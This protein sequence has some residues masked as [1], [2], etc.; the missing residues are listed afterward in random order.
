MLFEM[1][2]TDSAFFMT[3]LIAIIFSFVSLY[4]VSRIRH[5]REV[6]RLKEKL[7]RVM[8]DESAVWSE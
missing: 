4:I 7:E 3:Y 5:K 6:K 1:Q 8:K 2:F